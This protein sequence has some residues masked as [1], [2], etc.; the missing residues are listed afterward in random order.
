MAE[1]GSSET[2]AQLAAIAQA[3]WRVFVHSLRTSRGTMELASRIFM[4]LFFGIG[5]IGGAIGL[6]AGAYYLVAQGKADWVAALFWPVFVFWQLFPVMATAFSESLD[7]EMLLRFPLNYPSYFLVR[8]VY[9]SLDVS[10]ALGL[11]WSTAIVIGV[12]IAKMWLL[13][14]TAVVAIA[15][16]AV[17]ISLARLI[18]AWVERWLAQRRTREIF[19]IVILLLALSAQLVGPMMAH[20]GRRSAP[21]AI[22]IG[23]DLAP[24]QK[25]IPPGTAGSAI[26]DA[27]SGHAATGFAHLLILCAYLAVL[28]LLLH[29]RL[30]KQYRGENLSETAERT[31]AMKVRPVVQPS[32]N[33]PGMRAPVAAILEKELRYL[34]RSGPMLFTLIVPVFMLVIFRLG[35]GGSREAGQFLTRTPNLAFPIAAAYCLLL[36]TNLVYNTFGADGSGL[37]IFLAAPIRFRDIVIGKNLAHAGVLLA[38]LS[39]VW[40]GV[41]LLFKPPTADVTAATLAGIAFAMPVNFSAGDLLSFYSPKKIDYGMLGRQRASQTSILVSFG[42]QFAVISLGAL[43]VF[44]GHRT[45]SYWNAALIFVVLAGIAWTAYWVVLNRVDALSLRQRENLIGELCRG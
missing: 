37:Q 17:N 27:A 38:E 26:A 3:R 43:V 9:G 2:R 30:K 1:L 24:E 45:G 20:Y 10:T 16:A 39:V 34:L 42:I 28:L 41:F 18:F 32:W 14:W 11:T 44:L 8:M 6:A 33:L 13:P 35:P 12:G 31:T 23:Q 22:R 29:I 21:T 19:G 5:G 25:L 40:I 7:P 36:L 4:S 15:F